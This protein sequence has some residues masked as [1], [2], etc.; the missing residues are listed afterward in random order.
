[1]TANRD[2]QAK[3]NWQ[4]YEYG[5]MRGHQAYCRHARTAEN[6]YLG[7]GRQWA[8]ED[9]EQ[10]ESEGRPALEFNQVKHKINTAI[11]Y[12]IQ[13]RMDMAFRPRGR[14]ADEDV[15]K[16]LTKVAAQ[17]ADNT[18]LHWL[19]TQ[20]FADGLIQQRGYFDIR[21]SY[22]DSMLGEICVTDLDPL[23]VIPDPDAK[24]Y[25]PD[26]WQ[27]VIINRW[28]TYDEIEESYGEKAREAV[29]LENQEDDDF[30]DDEADEE[31]NKFGNEDSGSTDYMGSATLSDGSK[32]VRVIERQFWQTAKA[33]V[34]ISLTGDIRSVEGMSEEQINAMQGVVR[35]TR[36][37]RRVRWVISTYNDVLFDDWSPFNHF[38]VVPFFPFFRRGKTSGLVDDAIGPQQLLNKTM[39]QFLH[40]VNTTANGGWMWW[41]D[42]LA[43]M[44][45]DDM[46]DR[47][48]EPGLSVVVKKDTPTDKL[49]RK[50]Q[51]N[52]IPTGIDRIID[53]AGAMLDETTGINDAMSGN[54]GRE[55]SGVAIQSRQFAAQQGLAVPLDNLARTRNMMAR[56]ILELVQ[57]FY[58]EPRVFR[59]TEQDSRGQD[60]TEELQV[61]YPTEAGGILNDLTL[62][63]YDVVVTEQPMQVTFENSQFTQIMEMREKGVR[64]PDSFV[65]RNSNIADKQEV[66][67]AMEQQAQQPP[68]PL[69][70]ARAKLAEAT[71]R[72]V[73][74]ETVNR[75]VEAQY[76]AIQTAA[77][78]ATQPSTAGLADSLLRSAGYE[79][80]D[81]APIVPQANLAQAQ[82]QSIG[83][84]MPTNTNP[85][86]PANPGIGLMDGIE[87]QSIE[88]VPA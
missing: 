60:V 2:D 5:R 26:K 83:Q 22:R 74:Q 59:I 11:G 6:F 32:R 9:R 24:S 8:P 67:E 27:D 19:E 58:D 68:D 34:V 43:N 45:D 15:A 62:G 85:L 63:E 48:A 7:G 79:D 77:T 53:R 41:A 46:A 30:G 31:R 20:V 56:R 69:N 16:A 39:S 64:I 13:N 37:I 81:A 36:R 76:S 70:E 29:A 52:Q 40:T 17:V 18:N 28:L 35:A 42:T 23:D 10:L 84:G 72:K 1:M 3:L 66:I 33:Q 78:I 86:T 47:G 75:S 49:P 88:G 80:Q 25:D 54:S 14:G 12:Q 73:T 82:L 65:V 87:T 50:I 55:V 61:N 71:A 38:T 44:S 57:A 21:I 51:A 4:R